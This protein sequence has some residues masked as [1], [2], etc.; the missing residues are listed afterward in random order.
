MIRY[1]CARLGASEPC[2]PRQARSGD[3]C[4]RGQPDSSL[5]APLRRSNGGGHSSRHPRRR[6]VHSRHTPLRPRNDQQRLLRRQR[7]RPRRVL[8]RTVDNR[9]PAMGCPARRG[10]R[11]S[12]TSVSV[13]S[14]L[15]DRRPLRRPVLVRRFHASPPRL[16]V[17]TLACAA[18]E[19]R[20]VH[21]PRR[22]GVRAVP[23]RPDH[24]EGGAFDSDT[25]RYL[26]AELG[27]RLQQRGVEARIFIVGGA[28]MG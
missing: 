24:I 17:R 3:R 19:P 10:R 23:P 9:G 21:R 26:L 18:G 2:H 14:A 15:M 22:P 1:T 25:I 16:C 13:R 12:R 28:A 8:R 4:R 5:G 20:R 6:R 7:S 11:L 27:A